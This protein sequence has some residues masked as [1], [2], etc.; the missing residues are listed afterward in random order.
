MY[1]K[2]KATAPLPQKG[3][4]STTG[5]NCPICK[6]PIVR[7]TYFHPN[8]S[9]KFCINIQCPAKKRLISYPWSEP[10]RRINLK[11]NDRVGII[12]ESKIQKVP[13]GR[14]FYRDDKRKSYGHVRK[15]NLVEENIVTTTSHKVSPYSCTIKYNNFLLIIIHSSSS[16]QYVII[17]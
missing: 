15:A 3:W 11:A 13:C 14:C 4:L 16:R 7:A 8:H 10:T 2:C 17:V 12:V 6:W 1:A 9:R 5:K